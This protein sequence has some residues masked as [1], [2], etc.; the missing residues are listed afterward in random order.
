MPVLSFCGFHQREGRVMGQ[1]FL[2][3]GWRRITQCSADLLLYRCLHGPMVPFVFTINAF[4]PLFFF[5]KINLDVKPL[6]KERTVSFEIY[7]WLGRNWGSHLSLWDGSNLLGSN[8]QLCVSLGKHWATGRLLQLPVASPL[9][10]K[11]VIPQFS[12]VGNCML[13]WT[14]KG[15]VL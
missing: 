9:L 5:L 14:L 11:R 6:W 13:L 8:F 4:P 12:S 1:Q 7:P 3:N 15:M 10:L 2:C